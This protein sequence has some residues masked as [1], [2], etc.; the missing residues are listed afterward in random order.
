MRDA[1]EPKGLRTFLGGRNARDVTTP[2]WGDGAV[3]RP[4]LVT[5]ML[6]ESLYRRSPRRVNDGIP[7]NCRILSLGPAR[8]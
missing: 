5:L 4:E 2:V 3:T 1:N 7:I 8:P 6:N